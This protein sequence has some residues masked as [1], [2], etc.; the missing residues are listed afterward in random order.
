MGRTLTLVKGEQPPIEKRSHQ[1]NT[2]EVDAQPPPGLCVIAGADSM[3]SCQ[4][5]DEQGEDVESAPPGIADVRAQPG[6]EPDGNAKVQRHN[7]ESHPYWPVRADERDEDLA[8]AKMGERINPDSQDMHDEKDHAE[9]RQK[10]MQF[11]I[12]QAGPAAGRF[13]AAS[14]ASVPRPQPA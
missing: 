11:A 2:D 8:P 4:G 9:Q 14:K 13:V 3:N 7:T 10:V 1:D 6:T 12:E 5:I